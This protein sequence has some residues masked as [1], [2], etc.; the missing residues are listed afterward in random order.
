MITWHHDN[1]R[2]PMSRRGVLPLV[3]GLGG[4]TDRTIIGKNILD[5][6]P[7]DRVRKLPPWP[8]AGA[9]SATF[10]KREYRKNNGNPSCTTSHTEFQK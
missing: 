8:H 5:A 3:G 6:A 9:V 10:G 1:R 4:D 7:V 2:I